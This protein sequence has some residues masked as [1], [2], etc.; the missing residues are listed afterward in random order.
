MSLL[1]QSDDIEEMHN[2]FGV[3]FQFLPCFYHLTFRQ[4]GGR[5]SLEDPGLS[6]NTVHVLSLRLRLGSSPCGGGSMKHLIV[7]LLMLH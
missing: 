5:Y 6:T 2:C 4:Q 7:S 1:F 3:R